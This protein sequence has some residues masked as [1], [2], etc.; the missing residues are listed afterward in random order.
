MNLLRYLWKLLT[1]INERGIYRRDEEDIG[2]L[3]GEE[4]TRFLLISR[5]SARG[6]FL[7]TLAFII[8]TAAFIV[9]VVSLIISLCQG[10]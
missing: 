2:L 4:N 3:R 5:Q 6:T 9:S 10:G 7:A 8:A 1:D